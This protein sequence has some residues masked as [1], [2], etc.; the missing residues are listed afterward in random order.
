MKSVFRRPIVLA[1]FLVAVGLSSGSARAD[2]QVVLSEAGT[3]F[4]TTFNASGLPTA[5][6][7]SGVTAGFLG[8]IVLGDYTI[9]SMSGQ[10]TQDDTTQLLG[11]TVSVKLTGSAGHDLDISIQANSY[12]APVTPPAITADSHLAGTVNIGSAGDSISLT[13]SVATNFLSPQSA[14]LASAGNFAPP[15]STLSI[16]S[17]SAPF[18]MGQ[19][20][21]I[22]LN[23][24]NDVFNFSTSVILSQTAVP[25]P[26]TL[27]IASIGLLGMVGYRLR[28]RRFLNV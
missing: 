22:K 9:T 1:A 24:T 25:E 4:S 13:S 19:L 5:N 16:N 10:E 18:T 23:T 27:T 26:S 8:S 6:G 11:A 7:G 14:S 20:I 3:G 2:V 12:T 28:R 21:D 17:L 15:D